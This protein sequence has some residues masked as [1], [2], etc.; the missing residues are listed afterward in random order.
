MGGLKRL[1]R[2]EKSWFVKITM[3][4]LINMIRQNPSLFGKLLNFSLPRMS[5]KHA[6]GRENNLDMVI[7]GKIGQPACNVSR[8]RYSVRDCI[9]IGFSYIEKLKIQ[10]FLLSKD[11]GKK[12]PTQIKP[13][14]II[15]IYDFIFCFIISQ[16]QL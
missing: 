15:G 5:W 10:S 2:A 14:N 8:N 12:E 7:I 4:S 16:C 3:A 11:N 6:F 1:A 9:R 13:D